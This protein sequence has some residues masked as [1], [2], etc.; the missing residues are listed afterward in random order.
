MIG[1]T[2]SVPVRGW[3]GASE[4][5][6]PDEELEHWIVSWPGQVPRKARAAAAAVV[7]QRTRTA[8]ASVAKEKATATTKPKALASVPARRTGAASTPTLPKASAKRASK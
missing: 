7:K 3:V 5:D 8:L 2:A 4:A 6:V 1:Q